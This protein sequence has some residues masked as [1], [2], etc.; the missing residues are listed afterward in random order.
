MID[1]MCTR[2]Q[3]TMCDE[4]ARCMAGAVP[5]TVADEVVAGGPSTGEASFADTCR[6]ALC[7]DAVGLTDGALA[8][9]W[10]AVRSCLTDCEIATCARHPANAQTSY[11]TRS[12][13]RYEAWAG[14]YTGS[15]LRL[16][17][18]TVQPHML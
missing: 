4:R 18:R 11:S 7:A 9:Q 14:A 6:G 8:R 2:K 1:G 3:F 16:L 10:A 12:F 5:R 17:L 15:W 13:R